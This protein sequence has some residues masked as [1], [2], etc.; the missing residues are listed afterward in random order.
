MAKTASQSAQDELANAAFLSTMFQKISFL[1]AFEQEVWNLTQVSPPLVAGSMHLCAG[2]EVVPMAALA[3]LREDD[4]VVCTYRGHG[5]ALA[6]SGNG[7][8]LPE[9]DGHKWRAGGVR[10]YDGARIPVHR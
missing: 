4:P 1:R 3:A 8:N 5:W 2:Q 9:F 6:G 7:G 10:L